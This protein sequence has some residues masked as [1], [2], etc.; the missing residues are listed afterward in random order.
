MYIL[1]EP[2]AFIED[3]IIV[4]RVVCLKSATADNGGITQK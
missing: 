2:K 3:L 4:V 1:A